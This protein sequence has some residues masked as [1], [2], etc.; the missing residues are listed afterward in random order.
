MK[1]FHILLFISWLLICST[2]TGQ[3]PVN[4]SAFMIRAKN[5][6]PESLACDAVSKTFIIS[7]IAQRKIIMMDSLGQ[8]RDFIANNQYG[9][10]SGLGLKTDIKEG[11]LWAV[12]SAKKKKEA[13]LYKFDLET[14]KLLN[15][16]VFTSTKDIFLN[17]LCFDNRGHIY[18]T[19]SHNEN[20]YQFDTK[21]G[22]HKLY[23]HSKSIQYPNGITFDSLTS[24]LF[25]AGDSLGI[26]K[27]SL[28]DK[29]IHV[30]KMPRG[31]SS[32]GLD[33]IYFYRNS[34]VAIFNGS[35]NL[36]RHCVL[37]FY[38]NQDQNSVIYTDTLYAGDLNCPTT[39]FI[40]DSK[41]YFLSKTNIPDLIRDS[42][43]TTMSNEIKVIPLSGEIQD[44]KAKRVQIITE[45][46]RAFNE[47]SW[48]KVFSF[49]SDEAVYIDQMLGK[50]PVYFS[51]GEVQKKYIRFRNDFPDL[52]D[53]IVDIQ[54]KDNVATVS[55][56]ITGTQSSTGEKLNNPA[57][58]ILTFDD[59]NRIIKEVTI[60]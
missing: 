48:N 16:Y 41:F 7:S 40:Q 59:Q 35:E 58:I 49:Y 23:F 36:N 53:S 25:I 12:S 46:T 27:L 45:L 24:S 11:I 2:V 17:D 51:K 34:I 39:G 57:T 43:A 5:L 47:G 29:S 22:R 60:F 8:V 37:Q 52:N 55:M 56:V 31:T 1:Q 32:A 50:Q 33:G 21:T 18:L 44:N 38:L 42:N 10:E 28:A 20:I 13:W 3:Q 14:K 15:K 4:P 26:V 19:D 30:L 54:I 6:F 9:F